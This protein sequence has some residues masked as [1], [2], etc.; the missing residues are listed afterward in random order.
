MLKKPLLKLPSKTAAVISNAVFVVKAKTAMM[1]LAIT[2]LR[3]RIRFLP[4]LSAA[5]PMGMLVAKV[6]T[7]MTVTMIPMR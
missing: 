2:L 3:M 7:P 1:R 5:I 4:Y 6:D